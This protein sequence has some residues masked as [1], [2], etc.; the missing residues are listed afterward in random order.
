MSQADYHLPALRLS[1]ATST[2]DLPNV[3]VIPNHD[4]DS[5]HPVSGSIHSAEKVKLGERVAMAMLATV[6]KQ[7][8]VVWSG[9]RPVT[10]VADPGCSQM[11]DA[12]GSHCVV[13]TF[14]TV[15]KGGMDFD[16]KAHCP[17]DSAGAPLIL[18]V[19]CNSS[20]TG[21]GFELELSGGWEP[22]E[23]ARAGA[24]ANTVV[25]SGASAATRIRYA[26]SDWPVS[27]VR[28][29]DGSAL[30]ARVFDLAVKSERAETGSGGLSVKY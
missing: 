7:D 1:Q 13:V 12:A 22:A 16:A 11:R 6:Y 15:A 2:A 3:H 27:A 4:L 10:V 29:S 23:S 14:S 20:H 8:G 24:A 9:P 5:I 25:V 18:P 30:P 17:T 21:A 28:N 19:Y 26:Y